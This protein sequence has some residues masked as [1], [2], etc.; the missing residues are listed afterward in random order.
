MSSNH[1]LVFEKSLEETDF[2]LIICGKTG[3]LKGLWI[4]KGMEEE[5]VPE[6]LVQICVEV[7]GVD[8]TE[9]E[10]PDDPT[11]KTIH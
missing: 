6:S 8:P 7:F 4:P 2:G 1:E 11:D 3:N 5:P 10:D 9:F